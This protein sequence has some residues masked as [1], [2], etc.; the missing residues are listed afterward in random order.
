MHN[1]HMHTSVSAQHTTNWPLMVSASRMILIPIGYIFLVTWIG[2]KFMEKKKPYKLKQ[3]IIA[4][5][6]LQVV[7][8]AI[9]FT[10]VSFTHS[11]PIAG[12]GEG[13]EYVK[14]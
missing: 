2:P 4:Y 14:L 13:R 11:D 7:S 8:C 3:I 5:N 12:R 9:L 1:L 10:W 6:I